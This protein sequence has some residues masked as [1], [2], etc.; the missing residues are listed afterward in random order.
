VQYC[1]GLG[2]SDQ[3]PPYTIGEN[4]TLTYVGAEGIEPIGMPNFASKYF[5]KIFIIL[6]LA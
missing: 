5:A 4:H 3:S 6:V 2:E 1:E